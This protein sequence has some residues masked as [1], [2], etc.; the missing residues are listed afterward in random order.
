MKKEKEFENE[1]D[2]GFVISDAF[3]SELNEMSGG[4]YLIFILDDDGTPVIYESFD[5]RAYESL[6]KSFASDWLEA[7]REVRKDIL[8]DEISDQWFNFEGGI[9]DGSDE[10]G[11]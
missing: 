3:F 5:T 4:G 6:V 7:D 8:K 10:D 9:E 2:D 1:G 11:F